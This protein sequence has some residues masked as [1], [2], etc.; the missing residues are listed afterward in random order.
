VRQVVVVQRGQIYAH[1]IQAVCR[2][3][4]PWAD[5]TAHDNGI[6]TL[7]ALRER[8]ADLLFLDLSFPDLHGFAMLRQVQAEKLA[9]RTLLG[10]NRRDETCLQLLRA[11]QIDGIVDTLDENAGTVVEALQ[12]V[13]AGEIFVSPVYR[14]AVVN[15][16]HAS[17]LWLQLTPAEIRILAAIGDGSDDLEAAA[18]TGLS[19]ATVQT[20]RRNIMRKL[21]VSSSPKLVRE[22]I[23]LG[24]V[25]ITS[26]GDIIRSG[27]EPPLLAPS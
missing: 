27:L 20:H 10:C 14:K 15:R 25:H 22:A 11:A 8:P 13:A 3:A 16:T 5:V 17:Q 7:A 12:L 18:E 4:F 9:V 23:R 21:G 2:Q 19:A 26:R 1:A 24:L 6:S